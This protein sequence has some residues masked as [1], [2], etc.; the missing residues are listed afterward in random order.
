MNWWGKLFGGERKPKTV[1]DPTLS[2]PAPVSTAGAAGDAPAEAVGQQSLPPEIAPL[3]EGFFEC[4]VPP[5]DGR[6]SDKACPCPEVLIPR[7]T[8]YLYIDQ[9]IIDFRKQHPRLDDANTAMKEIIDQRFERTGTTN[10]IARFRIVPILVCEQGAKLRNL[11]LET[12]AQ[13]AR[14]WWNTG[15]VPLRATPLASKPSPGTDST[16]KRSPN[17]S[18]QNLES[19]REA[20]KGAEEALKN[21]DKLINNLY[22][23]VFASVPRQMSCEMVMVQL[24]V[25][26]ARAGRAMLLTRGVDISFALSWHI[27]P[28]VKKEFADNELVQLML[29]AVE[30]MLSTRGIQPTE[31]LLHQ[32][33]T[34]EGSLRLARQIVEDASNQPPPAEP[35]L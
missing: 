11:D 32:L 33:E 25:A 16:T 5:G 24:Q 29:V 26:C 20:L 4:D 18:K 30:L 10:Y 15:L 1:V 9:E 13:D 21:A 7:G 28:E 31:E 19:A 34:A 17:A 12:A 3:P 35:V 23:P 8:G 6:C 14:H 22:N 27:W 2:K